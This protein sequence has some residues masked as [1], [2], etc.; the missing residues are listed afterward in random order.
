M[1]YR[2]N[3][4]CQC[5]EKIARARWTLLTSRRFCEFCEI[6]QKE[7]DLVPRAAAIVAIVIAIAGFTAYFG[8]GS[9]SE[10]PLDPT[11]LVDAKPRQPKPANADNASG[12]TLPQ[13]SPTVQPQP[14][15]GS[16]RPDSMQRQALSNS[17]TEAVY[18]CGALT[19]KGTPCTRRVKTPGHCWQHGGT[20]PARDRLD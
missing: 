19:R 1:L 9:P 20:R 15:A 6:E 5:G 11:R 17:S 3:F 13:A 4:C 14:E 18:Y 8:S 16:S 12:A 2:P 10:K 7:Y